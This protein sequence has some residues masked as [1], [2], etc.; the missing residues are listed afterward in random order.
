MRRTKIICT[1]GPASSSYETLKEMMNAGMNV[2]RI[3]F[4]H[5]SWED[6]KEKVDLIKRVRNDLQLP[7]AILIDT[8]GPEIRTGIF[9][10][11]VELRKNQF[12]TLKCDNS[13]GCETSVSISYK[14]LA[15]DVKKG[16][17]ILV[18]DGKIELKVVSINDGHV[19]CKVIN[20]GIISSNKSI[21]VPGVRIELESLT[22]KDKEDIL[23][24]IKNK[25][26]FIAAS[27]VR[28]KEDVLAIRKILNKHHSDIKIISKIE[29]IEG[30]EN[31]NEILKV[32]DGIMI[33]RGDLGV[34]IPFYEV[35]II[36]KEFI[37]KCIFFG[38]PVIIATQMMESMIESPNPT[39]AEV[40]DVANAIFDGTSAV[41][42]SGETAVGKYPIKCIKKMNEIA[43]RIEN[44]IDYWEFFK[45]RDMI[46]NNI[47][48]IINH[49]MCT[50]ALNSKAKAIFCYTYEGDTPRIISSFRPSCP[51]YVITSNKRI[52]Y[53]SGLMWGL[54]LTYVRKEK[55]PKQMILNNIER[56]KKKN[57]INKDDIVIIA[58]GKY[59]ENDKRDINKS[60]GGIYKI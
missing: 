44:N 30:V 8:K 16:N 14:K 7:V 15:N 42:L 3:N 33:A 59:I 32:S 40:S 37:R 34:E 21:N 9:D 31:F 29:N 54:N 4:S 10:E 25:A 46:N 13:K 50:T 52:Y 43:T 6:Q 60:I 22:K 18:D 36:Q 51:I 38:K 39:R 28:T 45:K 57:L 56:Y 19:K 47:E 41:M 55:E 53:K 12:F 20:E 48:F 11:P 58:G 35:P 26:D 23:G 5:G 24:A 17:K 27:F 2:A 49:S 1:I